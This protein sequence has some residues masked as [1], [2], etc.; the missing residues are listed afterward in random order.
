MKIILFEKVDD[1]IHTEVSYDESM[2]TD[3]NKKEL[4]KNGLFFEGDKDKVKDTLEERG[5]TCG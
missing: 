1:R 3:E 2:L 5:Y 4:I